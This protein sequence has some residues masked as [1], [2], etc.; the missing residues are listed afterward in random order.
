MGGAAPSPTPCP[1]RRP[2]KSGGAHR[3]P[4]PAARLPT[5]VPH[6][7]RHRPVVLRYAAAPRPARRR[8]PGATAVM[9]GAVA[10]VCAFVAIVLAGAWTGITLLNWHGAADPESV[11]PGAMPAGATDPEATDPEATDPEATDPRSVERPTLLTVGEQ[12]VVEGQG[13]PPPP[14]AVDRSTVRTDSEPPSPPAGPASPAT[15]SQ[16]S[17]PSPST[18]APPS[19]AVPSAPP[20]AP[21]VPTPAPPEGSAAAAPP[22][23]TAETERHLAEPLSG[24]PSGASPAR[25]PQHDCGSSQGNAVP[26]AGRPA[27]PAETTSAD[28]PRPWP[29]VP[30]GPDDDR[31]PRADAPV[32]V[33]RNTHG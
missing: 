33:P 32:G 26:G 16:G 12:A 10:V 8:R 2:V 30:T 6:D 24:R 19:P 13:P 25:T 7:E 21:T 1:G 15:A 27:P 22:T 9:A 29:V 23:G 20:A 17:A 14:S 11:V 5:L 28:R 4:R 18:A 3:A 31:A